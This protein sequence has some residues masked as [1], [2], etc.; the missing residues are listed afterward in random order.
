MVCFL[1][2]SSS[3]PVQEIGILDLNNEEEIPVT[4]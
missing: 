3:F 1:T 4:L 2:I